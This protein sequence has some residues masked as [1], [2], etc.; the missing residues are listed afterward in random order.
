MEFLLPEVVYIPMLFLVLFLIYS[1]I[2]RLYLSPIA[3]IPGP[4]LAALTWWYEYY[5]DVVTYGKYIWKVQEFHEQYGPIV[6]ISPYEVHINDP[7]FFETLYAA[8]NTNR[9][10]RWSW[11]TAGLGLPSCTVGMIYPCQCSHPKVS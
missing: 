6:R 10:D 2:F 4:K 11:Y 3:N 9:K 1:V 5:H 8:T 7:D